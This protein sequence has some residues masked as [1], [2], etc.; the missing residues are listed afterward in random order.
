MD[1]SNITMLILSC[2]KFSDLW[3]GHIEL[4]EK[5]WGDREMATYIVT[6]APNGKEYTHAKVFSAGAEREWT[7]RLKYILNQLDTEYIFVTLDDYYLI[8]KINNTQMS[9]L[10]KLVSDEGLDYLRLFPNPT[11]A[12]R[13][14]IKPNTQVCRIDTNHP[15]SVNLY[16]GI[17]KKNFLIYTLSDAMDVWHYEFSLSKRAIEYNAK[18][19]V[20]LN[21][22][23]VILDVVRKGKLLRKAAKYLK[24]HGL[25]YGDRAVCSFAYELRL[26]IQ[27][28]MSRHL[29]QSLK[30][31]IKSVLNKCGFYFYSTNK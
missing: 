5:N 6:D 15:Y 21:N 17:W 4:L 20:S 11:R 27:T 13:E 1:N 28:I 25:Y 10:F 29:P 24:K 19:A 14:E 12:T 9:D 26:C 8:E 18:C 2:D 30:K 3:D 31:I 7:E 22:E 16:T 23:F